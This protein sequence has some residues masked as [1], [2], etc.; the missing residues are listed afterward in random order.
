MEDG[1]VRSVGLGSDLIP[2]LS[3]VL[4]ERGI[5][6]DPS[7][8][9][10]LEH[11]LNT[12][13]FTEEELAEAA[14]IRTFMVDHGITKYNIDRQNVPSWHA[15]GRRIVFVPGQVEDDASIISGSRSITTNIGLL[16][17]V[18]A[19]SPNAFIV[20]K[21]HP[22]VQSGNRKG[23]ITVSDMNGLADAVEPAL[24]VVSCIECSDEVHTMTSLA[25]FDSL[26]RRKHVV[27][28]GEPFYAG[29]GLT[30]DMASGAVSFSRRSRQLTLD[31]FVAGALLRYPIYWD[32][33]L[34]GYASC[35]AV[36]HRIRDERNHLRESGKLETLRTG[37]FRRQLRKLAILSQSAINRS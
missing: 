6:F 24:S 5:Y 12:S 18:R 32:R 20:F 37:Y 35:M 25:G 36:L 34:K 29:W 10:D 11:I 2:P 19:A 27:T 13:E 23:K 1:F 9:S 14:D 16:Q 26:L 17:A 7:R 8:A 21:P 33:E 22:D 31:E 28:Y 30:E 4:D 15:G 3:I